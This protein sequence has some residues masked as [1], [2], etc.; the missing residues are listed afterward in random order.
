V[1]LPDQADAERLRGARL[2]AVEMPQRRDDEALLRM[3]ERRADMERHR[4]VPHFLARRLAARQLQVD[5]LVR[6]DERALDR[7]AQFAHVAGPRVGA[8]RLHRLRRQPLARAMARVQPLDDLHRDL[9]DVVLAL[10]Q[11]GHVQR[12]RRDAVEQ[13]FAQA[14]AAHRFDRIVMGGRDDAHVDRNR[15]VA[16]DAHDRV[17][18]ERAQ[19][20]DLQLERH[21]GDL[22][23][24][25]RAAA[26]GL[27]HA[28]V[29]RDRAGE[30]AFLVAEQLR[31]GD[32]AGNRAAIDRHER[33]AASR[34]HVVQQSRDNVLARAAFSHDQYACARGGDARHLQHQGLDRARAAEQPRAVIVGFRHGLISEWEVLTEYVTAERKKRRG[35][36]RL[37]VHRAY[38]RYRLRG[39]EYRNPRVRHG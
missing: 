27:E 39:I 2:V 15:F 31:L 1:P 13:V 6:E 32:I 36:R 25:Q 17:R 23:E 21:L 4:V 7:V 22:V 26:R 9:A 34:A 30:A 19:Q 18:L 38:R 14:P 5:L 28:D 24:K 29:L 10:A 33:P 16:A 3:R 20:L 37:F 8:Q 12:D 11:R 35:V